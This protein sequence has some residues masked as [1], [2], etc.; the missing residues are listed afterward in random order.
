[1]KKKDMVHI[2]HGYFLRLKKHFRVI[3]KNT[4]AE[5]IK[6]FRIEIKKLRAFLRLLE[7]EAREPDNLTLHG[8][9]K[10]MHK[11]GGRFRDLQLHRERISEAMKKSPGTGYSKALLHTGVKQLRKEKKEFLSHDDFP[12]TEKK[13]KEYLPDEY[14]THTIRYFFRSKLDG[15]Q[16]IITTARYSDK[17]MHSIR[18]QLKDV[19]YIIKLYSTDLRKALGF[20]FWSKTDLQQAKTIE[21]QLGFLNDRRNALTLLRPADINEFEGEDKKLLQRVKRRLLSEK[22]EL[23]KQLLVDLKKLN[24]E[25]LSR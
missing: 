22:R 1:M 10:D 6:P 24:L 5:T 7:L 21:D 13:I 20:R 4:T 16:K 3:Q 9:L 12:K 25:R 15:I 18:K 11:S 19:L 8:D 14:T 2:I 17:E 23:K